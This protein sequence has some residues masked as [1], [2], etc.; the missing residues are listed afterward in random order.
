M[1]LLVLMGSMAF[2]PAA[3]AAEAVPESTGSSEG[4]GCSGC[5]CGGSS[6]NISKTEITGAE[7]N[8][9][10][11]DALKNSEVKKLRAEMIERGFTPKVNNASA[12]LVELEGENTTME[13][14][15]VRLPF[16]GDADE[17]YILF[18]PGSEQRKAAGLYGTDYE[19]R[20][21]ASMLYVNETT[22]EVEGKTMT[23]AHGS[24]CDTCSSDA[25][26]I[27]FTEC[28]TI[29]TDPVDDYSE[30]IDLSCSLVCAVL[31]AECF[32]GSILA[33]L[34]AAATCSECLNECCEQQQQCCVATD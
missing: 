4:D 9:L 14:T 21:E 28:E 23:M 5:G 2:V 30:C 10:V 18:V 20:T 24:G 27:G 34:A 3:S 15:S 1:A 25:D 17:A 22:G 32:G 26:C 19:N 7:K 6:A 33:C 31:V 16:Q 12:T 13:I 29:C 11:S 8:K